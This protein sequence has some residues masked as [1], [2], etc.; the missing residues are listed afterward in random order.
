[1]RKLV[2]A[3]IVLLA[4]FSLFRAY[5]QPAAGGPGVAGVQMHPGLIE[6]GDGNAS[7][8]LAFGIMEK[9][10]D[11]GRL[12]SLLPLRVVF[13]NGEKSVS[14]GL[15]GLAFLLGSGASVGVPVVVTGLHRGDVVSAGGDVRVDGRVE[16]DVWAL[17]ANVVLSPGSEVTGDVV[18]IG[19]KATAGQ[20]A[21]VGGTVSQLPGL[22]IPFIGLLGTSFSAQALGLAGTALGYILFG[23]ALFISSYY[24]GPHA[25]GMLDAMPAL[26]RQTLFTVAVSIV[27]VPLV[28]ALLIA[29]IVGVFLLPLVAL[30]IFLIALD[31]FLVL[32]VLVGG[33]LRGKRGRVTDQSMYL[34]TSGLMA[35]FIL[36]TPA[37]VGILL[38][39]TR[40][41]PAARAGG[42]LQAI[43]MALTA[44]GLLYGFG[45]SLAY[46]RTRAARQPAAR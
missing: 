21:A 3:V 10:G 28:I 36:D 46:A 34:F 4:L 7:I 13:R 1:M 5:S 35:L 45:A 18:A 11:Q 38:T 43:G 24:L 14:I 39:V 33:W 26:W 12:L 41:T 2:V 19:G 27:A 37:L 42:V 20:G 9:G 22:K 31:G 6:V 25:K 23:F 40:S 32:C 16:G 15:N 17:G 8:G 30:L 44:A 29:S